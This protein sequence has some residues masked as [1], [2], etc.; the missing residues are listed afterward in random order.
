MPKQN[1]FLP[2]FFITTKTT[3]MKNNYRCKRF[4]KKNATYT[5]VAEEWNDGNTQFQSLRQIQKGKRQI[6][7]YTIY[8]CSPLEKG[9][10]MWDFNELSKHHFFNEWFYIDYTLTYT[11]KCIKRK[12]LGLVP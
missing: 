1:K 9:S 7:N 12:E 3:T 8:G 5:L 10:R 11:E 6:G 4:T 2:L